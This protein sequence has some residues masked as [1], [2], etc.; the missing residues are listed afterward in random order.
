MSSLI[1]SDLRDLARRRSGTRLRRG[2]NARID[3]EAQV[4][5]DLVDVRF[6]FAAASDAEPIAAL[7][8]GSWRRHYRGAFSD[9]FL[10]GDVATDRRIVWRERL[11]DARADCCTIV[12]VESTRIVGFV[13]TIL[14]EDPNWGALVDN[15]HVAHSHV[16]RGIGSRL[17]AL[18]AQEVVEKR[19]GSGLYLWVLEE[20]V[21]AQAFYRSRGGRCVERTEVLPPGGDLSR[22]KGAP[23]KLRYAWPDSTRLLD[24]QWQ[25]LCRRQSGR[26]L[27]SHPDGKLA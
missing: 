14:G 19:S 15:L 26:T 22:L 12:A 4:V 10:G 13:H 16:R 20:N 23:T 3:E 17:F 5:T 8:A 2:A 21:I 11:A 6:R 9:E 7:H 27:P 18:T 1:K 24:R 25:P